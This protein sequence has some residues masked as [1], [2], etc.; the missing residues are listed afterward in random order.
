MTTDINI[1][2]EETILV[3]ASFLS[4]ENSS[5]NSISANNIS[6]VQNNLN[7]TEENCLPHNVNNYLPDYG[8]LNAENI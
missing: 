8:K 7:P 5:K 3:D 1:N 4:D 2:S 6:L